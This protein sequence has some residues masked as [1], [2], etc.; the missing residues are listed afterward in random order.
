M[1]AELAA[2]PGLL[3]AAEGVATRTE[4]LELTDRVPVSMA[5]AT[6]RARARS[7]VQTEPERP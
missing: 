2:D 7:R 5:R 4:V 6:R 3:E 1:G